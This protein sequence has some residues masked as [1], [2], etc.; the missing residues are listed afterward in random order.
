MRSKTKYYTPRKEMELKNRN[1]CTQEEGIA[2]A[3]VWASVEG[4]SCPWWRSGER[5][6]LALLPQVESCPSRM[7]LAT[8]TLLEIQRD[9]RQ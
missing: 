5:G 9:E 8:F 6:R 1:Q 7:T 2:V 4:G 3:E